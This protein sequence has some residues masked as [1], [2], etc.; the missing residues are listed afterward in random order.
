MISAYAILKKA[1]AIAHFQ[2]GRLNEQQ[3]TLIVQVC[4]EIQ[5][6]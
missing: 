3:H 1:A 5:A 6:G 4:E 2:S